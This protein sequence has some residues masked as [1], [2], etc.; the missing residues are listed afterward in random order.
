MCVS[1]VLHRTLIFLI[2]L[3]FCYS[4]RSNKR[5]DIFI[6]S[7]LSIFLIYVVMS[8]SQLFVFY[9]EQLHTV[10]Y[11]YATNWNSTGYYEINF[12]ARKYRINVLLMNP[13]IH[14]DMVAINY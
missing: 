2:T 6:A 14:E 5:G 1:K 11:G 10:F 12:T 3:I 13:I 7:G 9:S 8:N 4:G